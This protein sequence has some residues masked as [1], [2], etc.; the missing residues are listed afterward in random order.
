MA[1]NKHGLSRDIPAAVKRQLRQEAGFGCVVCGMAIGTYEHIDPEFHDA[2]SHDPARM[3]FL[4]HQCHGKVTRGQLSKHAVKQAKANPAA[5]RNG[6]SF[7]FFDMSKRPYVVSV[8]PIQAM[9]C[10]SFLTLNGQDVLWVGAPKFAGGPV[11]LN[12]QLHRRDGSPFF[13][14]IENEW[15]VN[16]GNWD[17]ELVGR[18][19]TFKDSDGGI[20]LQLHTFAGQGYQISRI[21]LEING[22]RL[23]G[24]HK[25]LY[26]DTGEEPAM[27]YG[28][29]EVAGCFSALTIQGQ[30]IFVG[31]GGG[32]MAS[33][34]AQPARMPD[35]L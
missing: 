12:A 22:V 10:L 33:V 31:L 16:D 26:V 27:Q 7:E 35:K 14:I 21:D 23:L 34:T 3:A 32:G 28:L 29:C 25:V 30:D 1:K 11:L 24:N 17:F 4:C 19:M 18:R 5:K 9:E 15:R 2:K 20:P 13:E 6:F 8:G